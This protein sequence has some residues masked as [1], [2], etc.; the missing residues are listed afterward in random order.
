MNVCLP[1]VGLSHTRNIANIHLVVP[2]MADTVG[3]LNE[4]AGYCE[5]RTKQELFVK[6][7]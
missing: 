4:I 7:Q 1:A 3:R 2:Q 6:A 5:M